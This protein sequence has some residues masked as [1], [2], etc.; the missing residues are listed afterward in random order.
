MINY[1]ESQHLS[2]KARDHFATFDYESAE[3]QAWYQPLMY[4][5]RA[6]VTEFEVELVRAQRITL[7]N[8]WKQPPALLQ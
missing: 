2:Q 7:A 6:A 4:G 1:T 5:E 8:F 3:F